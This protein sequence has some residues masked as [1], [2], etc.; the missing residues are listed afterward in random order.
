[1]HNSLGFSFVDYY[2]DIN[3]GYAQYARDFE[4]L[5]T[6]VATMQFINYGTFDRADANG[7]RNGT[8]TAGEYAL[9][10]GWGAGCIRT[11]ASGPTSR[12]YTPLLKNT[13]LSASP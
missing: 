11:G 8:F 5:G 9:N 2:V 12:G 6:F 3:Y 4:K 7:E 13:T 1:M 10:I